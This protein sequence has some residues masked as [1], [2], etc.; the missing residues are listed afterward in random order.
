MALLD[1]MKSGPCLAQFTSAFKKQTL[2]VGKQEGIYQWL[3]INFVL[4]RLSHNHSGE[5]HLLLVQVIQVGH[6]FF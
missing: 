2:F 3:A 6:T 4:G 1:Q 5:T